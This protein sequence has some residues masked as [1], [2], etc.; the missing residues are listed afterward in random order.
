MALKSRTFEAI[1]LGYFVHEVPGCGRARPSAPLARS[2]AGGCLLYS[3]S[4]IPWAIHDYDGDTGIMAWGWVDRHGAACAV[5]GSIADCKSRLLNRAHG[6]I[7]PTFSRSQILTPGRSSHDTVLSIQRSTHARD[8]TSVFNDR[9]SRDISKV[10]IPWLPHYFLCRVTTLPIS[11]WLQRA[12]NSSPP[13]HPPARLKNVW[14][15]WH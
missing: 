6:A 4:T 10:A 1:A 5:G 15:K 14:E 9:S 11:S 13:P 3:F 12:R 8:A 2:P 7:Q